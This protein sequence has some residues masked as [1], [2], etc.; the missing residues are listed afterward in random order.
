MFPQ[1]RDLNFS[2]KYEK[3][4]L[5]KHKVAV[6]TNSVFCIITPPLSK[7]KRIAHAGETQSHRCPTARAQAS[8][9]LSIPNY[10]LSRQGKSPDN[11]LVS[12]L[13]TVRMVYHIFVLRAPDRQKLS[14]RSHQPTREHRAVD[15]F[16]QNGP[17]FVHLKIPEFF[18][19]SPLSGAGKHPDFQ[20]TSCLHF[21]TTNVNFAY[22]ESE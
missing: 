18:E 20:V 5:A 21:D 13:L 10:L 9:I 2:L 4:S 22:I 17:I 6:T 3:P 19:N 16:P 1:R 14:D 11:T 15:R 7:T 8:L 12:T